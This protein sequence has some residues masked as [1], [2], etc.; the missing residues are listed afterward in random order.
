MTPCKKYSENIPLYFY[1]EL[2]EVNRAE[3]D[4]HIKI[5][6]KCQVEFQETQRVLGRFPQQPALEPD[7]ETLSL[8]RN[9]VSLKIK[10][11]S[12]K[13]EWLKNGLFTFVSPRPVFQ[14]GFAALLLALG[15][16]V[17][18]STENVLTVKPSQDFFALLSAQQDIAIDNTLVEPSM[19]GIDKINYNASTGKVEITYNTINDIRLQG[20]MTDQNVHAL[21]Q[22]AMLDAEDY[23]VRLNAIKTVNAF[24]QAEPNSLDASYMEVLSQLL[25]QESN[26][27]LR[28]QVL[29]IFKVL[30]WSEDL[31]N[32]LQHVLLFDQDNALRIAAFR[33]ITERENPPHE[34]GELLTAAKNDSSTFIK[35]R[36][37]KLLEELKN[38]DS[39]PLRR[40][41]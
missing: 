17:G 6:P 12:E 19:L 40:E 34:L 7:D 37:E 27:G 30:P 3:L 22:H 32:V 23:S 14:L 28:L 10:E 2:S 4:A 38:T 16:F 18:K 5:C 1:N 8:L 39:T 41:D 36:A 13:R 31:K 11:K 24:A 29:K 35:Y 9:I 26:L 33:T 20:A 25:T 21:L 15:F